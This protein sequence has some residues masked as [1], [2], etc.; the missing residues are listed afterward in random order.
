M[1][2]KIGKLSVV[3]KIL[4][5]LLFF[6]VAVAW[7]VKFNVMDN[8]KP[9]STKENGVNVLIEIPEGSGTKKIAAILKENGVIRSTY[10][11]T[12]YAKDKGIDTKLR[13][14]E[15]ELNSSMTFE[16]ITV[17]LTSGGKQKEGVKF[18]I[19]EGYEIKQIADTLETIGLDHYDKNK[20]LE[21]VNNAENYKSDYE[22]LEDSKTLEGFLYPETYEIL[23]ESTE[24]D[25]VRKILNAF[26][27]VYLMDIKNALNDKKLNDIMVMASIVEREAKVDEER[28]IVAAVFYNRIEKGIKLESCATVQYALG[29]RKERLFDS[30][31]A[32]DSPYNT[33]KIKGLP[34]APIASPG[35]LSIIAA[36]HPKDVSYLYFVVNPDG[37]PGT[38]N[39][40]TTY[41]EFLKYK[42]IYINSLN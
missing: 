9:V 4:Y 13:P 29:E 35:R 6:I 5:I 10:S 32:I 28:D 37:N 19:P 17:V 39:F 24:D 12:N 2:K 7:Y 31:L 3:Q 25:I 15:F 23:K 21:L 1:K 22:F 20:F 40:A 34:P 36:L 33:Y 27:N 38:H 26:K 16:E 11:F 8:D 18:T 41:E 30:D 42:K 14:G